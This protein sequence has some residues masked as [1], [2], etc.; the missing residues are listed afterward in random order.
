M[1]ST[2]FYS[3]AG[4]GFIIAVMLTVAIDPLFLSPVR[5]CLLPSAWHLPRSA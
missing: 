5:C 3:F 2:R 1:S 4:V